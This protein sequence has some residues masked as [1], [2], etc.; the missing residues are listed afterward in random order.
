MS[1]ATV[2][3]SR[4]GGFTL[5]ELLIVIAI[6]A[7]MIA[8]LIPAVQMARRT[9]KQVQVRND[10]EQ[11]QQGIQA[12]K[13]HFQIPYIP[14]K[15]RLRANLAAYNNPQ[16]QLDIDSWRYLK[17][18]WPRLSQ[19]QVNGV[20]QPFNWCPN[21]SLQAN[22]DDSFVLEGDQCLVFFLGGV[23]LDDSGVP[24][25]LGFAKNPTYPMDT[26]TTARDGPF[27]DFP[28]DR[29][30][31]LNHVGFANF[32]APWNSGNNFFYS[33]LDIYDG[34]NPQTNQTAQRYNLPK[35]SGMPYLYFS[36]TDVGNDYALYPTAA[37]ATYSDCPTAL[38]GGGT[39]AV[40]PYRDS[41]TRFTNDKGFQ[42][43]SAGFDAIY[44]EGLMTWGGATGPYQ[45]AKYGEDDLANFFPRTLS[46]K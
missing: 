7:I 29:L 33:F 35:N 21:Y 3:R 31:K 37:A 42:I 30:R 9:V 44:G 26:T 41:Q 2:I 20:P 43:I 25:C 15:L 10:L 13:T 27:F 39:T 24:R 6:I 38:T 45:G 40:L 22:F 16:D 14:S 34:A 4:R 32:K 46:S 12:F 17:R 36:A 23:Q 8:L 5:V 11:L 1:S 28:S 18:V 19:P